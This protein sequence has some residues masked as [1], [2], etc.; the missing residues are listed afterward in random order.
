MHVRT[1]LRYVLYYKRAACSDVP[2][3]GAGVPPSG[4]ARLLSSRYS[5][6]IP[7]L[8]SFQ[9]SHRRFHASRNFFTSVL[10]HAPQMTNDE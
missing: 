8:P 4:K 6:A 2:P 5:S 9:N 10:R 7:A 3:G 1:P